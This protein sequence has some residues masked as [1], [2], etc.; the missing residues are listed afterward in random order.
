[1]SFSSISLFSDQQCITMLSNH[2][3]KHNTTCKSCYNP[4]YQEIDKNLSSTS[5][6]SLLR[7]TTHPCYMEKFLSVTKIPTLQHLLYTFIHTNLCKRTLIMNLNCSQIQPNEIIDFSKT[8]CSTTLL[9]IPNLFKKQ[10]QTYHENCT[11][12]KG[13]DILI[14]ENSQKTTRYTINPD[15]ETQK[16]FNLIYNKDFKERYNSYHTLKII[17][18]MDSHIRN[19]YPPQLADNFLNIQKVYINDYFNIPSHYKDKTYFKQL[20]TNK[21]CSIPLNAPKS[22]N[23]LIFQASSIYILLCIIVYIII[24]SLQ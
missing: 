15:A 11:I 12:H 9:P 19:Y 6:S 20:S 1:M 4:D 10:L 24:S 3:V 16:L 2:L 22:I 21:S 17:H 14:Q 7:K 18:E 8:Q 13:I 23:H 5:G